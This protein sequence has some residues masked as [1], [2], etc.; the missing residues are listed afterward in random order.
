MELLFIIIVAFF[1]VPY[2]CLDHLADLRAWFRRQHWRRDWRKTVADV[3]WRILLA[4]LVI[5]AISLLI[6]FLMEVASTPE[7]IP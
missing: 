7:Q 5:G 1:L 6:C 3:G 4:S 2:L